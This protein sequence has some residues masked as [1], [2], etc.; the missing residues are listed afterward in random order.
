MVPASEAGAL[1]GRFERPAGTTTERRREMAHEFTV[2][3][4]RGNCERCNDRGEEVLEVG[5]ELDNGGPLPSGNAILCDL[6]KEDAWLDYLY[7]SEENEKMA[8]RC[9]GNIR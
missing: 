9:A 1:V 3:I 4:G 8:Q 2:G 7:W 6:C 5:S